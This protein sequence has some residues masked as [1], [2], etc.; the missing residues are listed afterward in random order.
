MELFKLLGTIAI[1]NKSANQALDETSEKGEKSESKLG[2]AFGNIGSAAVKVGKV[3][4]TGMIAAGT[5]VAGLVTQATSSYAEYEQ[6]VGGVETLFKDSASKVMEYANNAFQTAGMSANEYMT[7][8]TSFSASLLQS[9][10]GDTAAAADKADMAIRD[11]SDNANKMGTSMEMIQNAYNG[12]A[13]QNYTM[14]DNLKLG[15]GG[16]KEEMARLLADAEKISGQKFDLSSYGDIVDAIHVIQTEMGITG[17]TAAEAAGTISGSMASVKASW[18]NL[19][20][21]MADDNADLGGYIDT[22]VNSAATMVGNMLPR[23]SIALNGVVQLIEQLA[24]VILGKIPELLSQLLPSVVNAATGLIQALVDILPGMVTAITDMLPSVINGFESII[25]GLI[26]AIPSVVQALVDALPQIIPLL[27]NTIEHLFVT[28]CTVLPQIIQPIIEALPGLIEQLIACLLDMIPNLLDGIMTLI[29]SLINMLPQ[30]LPKIIQGIMDIITMIIDYIP[31][32]IPMLVEA[33]VQLINL[34][35]DQL[36]VIIPMLVDAIV[37]IIY[38]LVD[39]LPVIIPMLID[40]VVMIIQAIVEQLPGILMAL[41]DALP[42]ILGAVWDAIV[43]VFENLPQWFGQIFMGVLS[44]IGTMLAPIGQFFT[45]LW[46]GIVAGVQA[47]WDWVVGILSIVGTWIYDNVIAPVAEFFTGLWNGIVEAYHTVIDP[48]I[49][50]FTRIAAI[51]DEKV[52]QPVKNFFTGLWND[53]SKGVSDAIEV[54]KA[55]FSTIAGWV[56]AKVIQ[57]VKNFFAGLWD[58]FKNG[59]KNAWQGVKDVFSKVTSFFGDIFKKAWQKVKD[60]FSVGG[61]IFDGIKDGIVTAFKTVVNA[62]IRGI[63]KVVSLPFKGLNGI[64]DKIYNVEIVGIKPFDWLTWRAPIP[65]IPELAEGGVLKKG[66]TGYLEGDGDEAVVPL[67]RNTDWMRKVAANIHKF[68][69]DSVEATRTPAV[70]DYTA[71]ANSEET[72][73]IRADV[74]TLRETLDNILNRLDSYMPDVLDHMERPIPA[75]IGADQA[76]DMLVD[77]INY[78]LGRIAA[79]KGRGR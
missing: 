21:A 53:I 36:P 4:G 55:V 6:L 8:V 73:A 26:S 77:P 13:K 24:P 9:L 19:V 27:V 1:D 76:A 64:L 3:I 14:L 44:I 65:E 63:N 28:I 66:Q 52:I 32:I 29:S 40:A 70:Y 47:A 72:S 38:M 18:Q 33:V 22:F 45:D 2:K 25:D 50:I 61:K 12:F 71:R 5:A 31:V 48:W 23:I 43:M 57:P 56:D 41:I 68:M 10:G 75:I 42:E 62:I 17:T 51:V 74:A 60:V 78:R 37:Q 30:V 59:A 20:T 35:G 49:E 54:V 34:L 7:T 16:T 79:M 58:G 39:A 69:A 46:N 67:Q 15:Y 11:M